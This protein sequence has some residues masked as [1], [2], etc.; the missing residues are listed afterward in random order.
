I[1][2]AAGNRAVDHTKHDF[3]RGR[4]DGLGA[5]AAD[6]IDGHCRDIEG[7]PSI[8]GRLPRRIHLVA[9]LD[10]VSHHDSTES[11]PSSLER[12]RTAR[13]TVAP[14]SVADTDLRLPS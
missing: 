5:G 10:D 2:S 13:T 7:N 8:D 3:L 1:L 4:S 9:G 6:S 14:R 12:V 11:S